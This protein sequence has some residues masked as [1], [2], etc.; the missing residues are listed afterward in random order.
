[1]ADLLSLSRLNLCGQKTRTQSLLT[2]TDFRAISIFFARSVQTAQ[3]AGSTFWGRRELGPSVG[4]V[5]RPRL[6]AM[7]VG[8]KS[9][10]RPH[11]VVAWRSVR[12]D[13]QPS[14]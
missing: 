1:I 6:S 5:R 3:G 10:G 14:A 4:R 7:V 11:E 2:T 9:G 12:R 13:M 8:T